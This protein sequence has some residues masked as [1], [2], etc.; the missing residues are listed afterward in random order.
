MSD[1]GPSKHL[2]ATIKSFQDAGGKQPDLPSKEVGEAPRMERDVDSTITIRVVKQILDNQPIDNIYRQ[3]ETCQHVEKRLQDANQVLF[4][5][6]GSGTYRTLVSG[7]TEQH[8]PRV[9][10]SR[11]EHWFMS[12]D[13]TAASKVF[14]DCPM[15]IMIV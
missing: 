1:S 8:L 11:D 9:R 5:G 2:A 7:D 13:I 3:S 4:H 12:C 15:N 6:I 14:L 10:S